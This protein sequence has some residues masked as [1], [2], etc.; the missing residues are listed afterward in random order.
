M[1]KPTILVVDDDHEIGFMMKLMLEHK[2]FSVIVSERA[3]NIE[4]MIV[5]HNL[6]LIILDMLIAGIK[7]TDVCMS[8]KQ[9]PATSHLPILMITALPEAEATCRKAG[10]DDFLPKPFEMQMLITKINNFVNRQKEKV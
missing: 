8:I 7:G 3:D 4:Q 1:H 9:N 2:G 5:G 6:D 10:A